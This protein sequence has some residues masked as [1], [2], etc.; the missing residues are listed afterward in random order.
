MMVH[1]ASQ[2]K[3]YSQPESSE[4]ERAKWPTSMGIHQES[5]VIRSFGNQKSTNEN[6]VGQKAITG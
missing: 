1:G 5:H 4:H 3:V 6:L 2:T